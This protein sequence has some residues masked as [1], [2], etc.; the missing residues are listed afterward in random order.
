MQGMGAVAVS[1]VALDVALP[2]VDEQFW[3]D[4][5]CPRR[6][7]YGAVWACSRYS[8]IDELQGTPGQ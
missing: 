8:A 5:R 4:S 2:A 6:V 3:P 1:A 7:P